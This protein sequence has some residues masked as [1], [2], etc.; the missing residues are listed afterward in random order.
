MHRLFVAIRP[1]EAIR[2]LLI[3]YR[4]NDAFERELRAKLPSDGITKTPVFVV[5]NTALGA[6]D[7][8]NKTTRVR[9][10][11]QRYTVAVAE[12]AFTYAEP[13]RKR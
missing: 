9:L 7:A 4:F 6:I 10:D 2:D 1:P 3:A 5:Q 12:S 8:Q 11:R 13:K